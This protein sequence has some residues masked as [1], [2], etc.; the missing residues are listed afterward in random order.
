ME[1]KLKKQ[2][3]LRGWDY[4]AEGYYFVT[5]CTEE[6]KNYFGKIDQAKVILSPIGIMAEKFW[7]AIP[8]HFPF[9]ELDRFIIMPNHIHGIIKINNYTACVGTQDFAFNN[10]R[11][12]DFAFLQNNYQNKFAPQSK[13]LSSIIRGFK[14]GVKKYATMNNLNFSWQTRFFDRVLRNE[15]EL[16]GARDYIDYNPDK[17]QWDNI[18]PEGLYM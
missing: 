7:L 3:R 14:I 17:W 5:I 11:T 13:N 16:N 6:R 12:Q 8:E 1:Y 18:K 9:V 4:S 2:Y 15:Q 10:K